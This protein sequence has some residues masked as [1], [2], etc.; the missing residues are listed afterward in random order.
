[1]ASMNRQIYINLSSED[2]LERHPSNT[3]TDFTV[4]LSPFVILSASENWTVAVAEIEFTANNL[5]P[6]YICSDL[7]ASS[8]VGTTTLPLLRTVW[9]SVSGSSH[10]FPFNPPF[11]VAVRKLITDT[12]RIYLRDKNGA[13]LSHT[14]QPTRVTLH[15]RRDTPFYE[16]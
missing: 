7:C 5:D 13:I 11:Y 8:P 4:T 14:S 2:D 1:M 3:P 16:S 9:P 15:L 10:V 6:F 12:I